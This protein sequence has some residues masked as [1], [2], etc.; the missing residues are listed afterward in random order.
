M[1]LR[2]MGNV[3]IHDGMHQVPLLRAGERC[4]LASLALEPNRRLRVETLTDRL[5]GD[6]PPAGAA[7]TVASYVRTVRKAIED[8]GGK[9]E[10][11]RNYRPAAYQLNIDPDLVDYHRFTALVAQARTRQR[12]RNPA[13]AVATYQRA[14][15][16]RRAEALGN[17]AG[18]WATDRGYAIEQEHLDAACAM[19]DQ[20]LAI[21]ECTAVARHATHLVMD[22]VPTDRMI[23]LAI[24]GLARSGQHAAIR[25]FLRRA[26]QRMWDIAQAQPSPQVLAL[27]RQLMAD[28][29]APLPAPQAEHPGRQPPD[30][31]AEDGP[32]DTVPASSSPGRIRPSRLPEPVPDGRVMMTA[33]HNQQV[34]QAAHDQYIAGA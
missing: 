25:G 17:V 31:P 29:G 32:Q 14:L 23:A 19:Y 30:R 7:H 16:L 21:G 1:E 11:L 9:R 10:W 2:L 22:V 13:D 34:Y 12:D 33:D 4:V 8:A 18:Q 3:E 20:Q 26:T 28:P 5:W 27:A 6:D 24:Q 15:A